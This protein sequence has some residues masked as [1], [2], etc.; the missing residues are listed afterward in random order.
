[1]KSDTPHELLS[2]AR[3]LVCGLEAIDHGADAVYIGAPRFGARAAAGNSTDDIARLCD[4]A[5][6]FGQRSMSPSTPSLRTTNWRMADRWRGT[7][8][9]PAWMLS[10]CR[11][12]PPRMELAAHSPA[13]KHTDGQPHAGEGGALNELGFKQIVLAR[14]LSLERDTQHPQGCARSDARSLRAWRTLRVVQ[15]QMLCLGV[16]LRPLCQPRRVRSVLP[17]ALHAGR[18]R[19]QHAH[20]GQ[21]PALAQ[22]HEPP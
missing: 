5:H 19:G 6:R 1:M 2:P 7:S 3:D 9:G 8:I 14:E 10:S 17:P 12:W 22:G 15:R 21:V 11:T 18:R 16:L 4:Y 20:Q 13:C